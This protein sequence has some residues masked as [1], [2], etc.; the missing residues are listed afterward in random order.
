[1]FLWDLSGGGE[2]T[3]KSQFSH[4]LVFLRGGLVQGSVWLGGQSCLVMMLMLLMRFQDDVGSLQRFLL[5]D[6]SHMHFTSS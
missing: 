5:R 4:K 3:W 6:F 1:M 2:L